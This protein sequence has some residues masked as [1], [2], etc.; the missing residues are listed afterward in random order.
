[1]VGCCERTSACRR[2]DALECRILGHL[3]SAGY[4]GFYDLELIGPR[5][6]SE[7]Y[8]PAILRSITALESLLHEVQP[9]EL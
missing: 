6:E 5:I 7:G 8:E 2:Y 1:M 3:E 9:G 4:R